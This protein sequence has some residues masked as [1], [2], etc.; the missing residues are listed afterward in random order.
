MGQPGREASSCGAQAS[1][2]IP[3]L[4][5]QVEEKTPTLS[6]WAGQPELDAS[7]SPQALVLELRLEGPAFLCKAALA[8]TPSFSMTI[9]A[10][11][12]GLHHPEPPTEPSRRLRAWKVGSDPATSSS[13]GSRSRSGAGAEP[14]LGLLP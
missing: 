13:C 5:C 2:R 1:A 14:S 9:V 6:S 4:P 3:P 11:G 7:R 12:A 8:P 10:L